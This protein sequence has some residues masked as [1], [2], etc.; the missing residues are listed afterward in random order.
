MNPA[1]RE[2]NAFEMLAEPVRKLVEEKG[3]LTPTDPQGKAIKPILEGKNV[4]LIAAT[5]TGKTE[6]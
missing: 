5:G 6:A 3:F 2:K 1:S 4:L